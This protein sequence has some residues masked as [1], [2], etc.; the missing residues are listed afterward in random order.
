MKN[1]EDAF[2]LIINP[3]TDSFIADSAFFSYIDAE[4]SK[5][6]YYNPTSWIKV[7]PVYKL[8]NPDEKTTE[9]LNKFLDDMV[10]VD[11]AWVR[12]REQL[13][14]HVLEVVIEFFKNAD[15]SG[16]FEEWSAVLHPLLKAEK[17]EF[18][19]V[20]DAPDVKSSAPFYEA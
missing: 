11:H 1:S 19:D 8:V 12:S 7:K 3:S 16:D 15:H 20:S 9:V 2:G 17:V 18:L 5:T 6:N 10:D 14:H 13:G 4:I